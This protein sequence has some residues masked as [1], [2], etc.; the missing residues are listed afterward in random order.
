MGKL[1]DLLCI[2][3]YI[4]KLERLKSPLNI[5]VDQRSNTSHN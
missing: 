3:N 4:Q 2:E 5:Y 1:D